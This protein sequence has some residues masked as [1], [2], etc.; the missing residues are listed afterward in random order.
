MKGEVVAH[1]GREARG[2]LA[3]EGT[4]LSRGSEQCRYMWQCP[5]RGTSKSKGLCTF[6][7]QQGARM[8][9]SVL[10]MV[11]DGHRGWSRYWVLF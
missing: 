1:S 4:H 9:G 11:L 7:G 5:G 6:Q 10:E 3:H 8:K 2:G